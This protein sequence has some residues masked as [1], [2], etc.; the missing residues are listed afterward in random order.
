MG[1]R[2]RSGP[3]SRASDALHS[4]PSLVFR[5]DAIG[6]F[7][8]V[9]FEFSII[10]QRKP[11]AERDFLAHHNRMPRSPLSTVMGRPR[12]CRPGWPARASRAARPRPWRFRPARSRAPK[13][14][15]GI[16]LALFA[17]HHEAHHPFDPVGLRACPT[18]GRALGNLPGR[19][20]VAS[21]RF[22]ETIVQGSD[23]SSGKPAGL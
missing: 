13:H 21:E 19:N 16:G 2:S 5:T 9:R 7:E 14:L 4:V 8:C 3:V 22:W 10:L 1:G 6:L 17:Y 11:A 12:A 20:R 23:R 15:Y 18:R